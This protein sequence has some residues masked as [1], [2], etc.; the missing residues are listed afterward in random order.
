VLFQHFD[1]L[2]APLVASLSWSAVIGVISFLLVYKTRLFNHLLVGPLVP[3]FLA[4]PAIMFAFLMG[5]MSAEAWQNFSYA[6][7][8]LI[9]EASAVSRLI[10]IPVQPPEYQVRST[11]LLKTYLQT[12]LND[13]WAGRHNEASSAKASNVINQLENNVWD[14]RKHCVQGAAPVVCMD[15]IATTA[16]IKGIDDLRNAREQ[17]LSLGYELGINYKWALAIFLAFISAISVA[18]VHRHDRK[19]G[20]IA[21]SLFCLS[22][23]VAFSM[24]SL[25][26]NPYK[27]RQT[28][29]PTPIV[30]LLESLNKAPNVGR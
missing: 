24:V 4:L 20:L 16:F 9:N 2:L 5:F 8:S 15:S 13:E 27:W 23:W 11:D 6:R 1:A 18:A 28:V 22:L 30:N 19:T 29:V 25:H 12:S 3:P 7:S 21:L 26:I 10:N 17:R 14:A